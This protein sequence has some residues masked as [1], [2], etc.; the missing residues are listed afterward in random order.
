MS[1]F[2][3][4]S[5]WSI[6]L[7]NVQMLPVYLMF[8]IIKQII[9]LPFNTTNQHLLPQYQFLYQNSGIVE[10]IFQLGIITKGMDWN[11]NWVSISITDGLHGAGI[12]EAKRERL[13]IKVMI[14][15]ILMLN[16]P[17]MNMGI[18][19]FCIINFANKRHLTQNWYQ[20]PLSD[21]VHCNI[22]L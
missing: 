17:M 15:K 19:C 16:S 18:R 7:I 10:F 12:L 11:K 3:N 9:I 20:F 21:C 22:I 2:F 1:L 4:L 5:C 8:K 6:V 14:S 13:F